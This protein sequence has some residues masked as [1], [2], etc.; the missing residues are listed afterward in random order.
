M[1]RPRRG[2]ALVTTLV[3][4]VL[5]SAATAVAGR[6][7][8]H[9]GR[10]AGNAEAAMVARNMAE[11]GVLAARLRM[12]ALLQATPDSASRLEMLASLESARGTDLLP[13]APFVADTLH[14]GV[15]AAAMVN[16]DTRIDI[17]ASDPAALT[18]LFRQ[19][20]D[21]PSAERIAQ[22][23]ASRVRSLPAES[24][25]RANAV[26]RRA[27]DSLA[28]ALLGRGGVSRALNP[29][30]SLDELDAELGGEAPWL[31]K[32]ADRLTVDGDGRL[33]I[34]ARGWK[35][36]HDLTREVQAVYAIEGSELRLL[37]WRER[38]R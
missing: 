19:V 21:A 37:R 17:N 15:F 25:A 9:A 13:P 18:G 22:R 38:D 29:Y 12:E 4:I 35:Q 2:V 32:I 16:L 14:D 30:E 33:L 11:S 23:I 26:R 3:L 20:A 1:T 36:G 5:L 7:V 24:A 34:V 8:R 10:L 6:G 28:S 31:G 27:Q